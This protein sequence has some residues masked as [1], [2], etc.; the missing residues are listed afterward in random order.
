MKKIIF[1]TALVVTTLLGISLVHATVGG[2]TIIDSLQYSS[3]NKQEFIYEVISYSGK[4][5]PPEIYSINLIDGTKKPLL[6]CKQ[7]DLMTDI[8]YTATLESVL[9]AYPSLLKHIDLE[10]NNFSAKIAV[11]GQ[12]TATDQDVGSTDFRL[13][14]FQNGESKGVFNYSG[15]RPEQVH[16]IE[17]YIIPNVNTLVLLVSTTNDCWEGGYIGEKLY[18]V[19]NVTLYNQSPLPLKNNNEASAGTG[20]LSVIAR[21]FI[22]PSSTPKIASYSPE[23]QNQN[24]SSDSQ[25]TTITEPILSNQTPANNSLVLEII[26]GALIIIIMI[27]ILKKH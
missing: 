19:P 4:G 10:K 25:S 27:L 14:L 12:K 20:N 6:T 13:D 24:Q 22:L 18:L 5:C 15:C 2:P 17:G 1:V 21:E 3:T 26:I 16:T 11:T 9:S 23:T 8:A 7:A